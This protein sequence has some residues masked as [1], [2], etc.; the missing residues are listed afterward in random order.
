MLPESP[1]LLLGKGKEEKA[2]VAIAKLN[3]THVDDPVTREVMAEL[4]DAIREENKE[5]K[6]GWL[7]CFSLNNASEWTKWPSR[8]G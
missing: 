6:A 2:L 3:D 8:A 1:R 5:G 7:E 4:G